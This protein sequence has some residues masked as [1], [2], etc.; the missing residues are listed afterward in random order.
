MAIIKTAKNIE[1][2]IKNK[3]QAFVGNNLVK[4][5]EKLVVDA[6]KGDLFLQATKKIFANGKGS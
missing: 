3:H 2:V 5:A 1:I 4:T 6:F